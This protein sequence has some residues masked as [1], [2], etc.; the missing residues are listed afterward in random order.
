MTEFQ[1]LLAA[2]RDRLLK[3]LARQFAVYGTGRPVSFADRDRI[4]A[5]VAGTNTRG[6]GIRTYHRAK[7]DWFARHPQHTYYVVRPGPTYKEESLHP[8]VILVECFG[9]RTGDAYRLLLDYVSVLRLIRPSTRAR[10]PSGR[11]VSTVSTACSPPHEA[12]IATNSYVKTSSCR[13]SRARRAPHSD[14]RTS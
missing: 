6:G 4:A 5:I 9:I 7:I 13:A 8:N 12:P 11:S 10:K 3:N 2:D 1:E 14:P